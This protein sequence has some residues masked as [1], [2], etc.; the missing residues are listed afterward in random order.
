MLSRDGDPLRLLDEF[1]TAAILIDADGIVHFINRAAEELL[2]WRRAAVSGRD[3]FRDL[4]ENAAHEG[5]RYRAWQTGNTPSTFSWLMPSH[6]RKLRCTVRSLRLADR[7]L[8]LVAIDDFGT[9]IGDDLYQ[10]RLCG[11]AAVGELAADTAHEINNLLATI[12]GFSQFLA[13]GLEERSQR[14]ATEYITAECERGSSIVNRLLTFAA[15]Q[16]KQERTPLRLQDVVQ[17]VLEK[18]R[19][20]LGSNGIEIELDLH[21]DLPQVHGNFGALERMTLVLLNIAE[22]ALLGSATARQLAVRTREASDGVV[23]YVSH[24]GP[25]LPRDR[26]SGPLPR[27]RDESGGLSLEAVE[28]VARQHFGTLHIENGVASGTTYTVRLPSFGSIA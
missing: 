26:L 19:Y 23:L 14:E 12:R 22:S 3:L 17:S 2:I 25:A 18:K 1:P 16:Q 13:E 11:M 24:N 9:Y 15:S 5:E 20:A 4:L 27:I 6:G 8:A 21:P 7:P 28:A 10:A